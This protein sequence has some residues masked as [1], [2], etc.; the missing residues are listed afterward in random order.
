MNLP[1]DKITGDFFL[2][3][4]YSG[5]IGVFWLFFISDFCLSLFVVGY[6]DYYEEVLEMLCSVKWVRIRAK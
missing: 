4:G 3:L 2:N 1:E 5:K 6:P